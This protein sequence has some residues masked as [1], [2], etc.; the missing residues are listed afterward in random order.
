MMATHSLIRA[1]MRLLAATTVAAAALLACPGAIAAPLTVIYKGHVRSV[2]VDAD[3]EVWSADGCVDT[4]T[5]LFGDH[6]M[7]WYAHFS[8]NY[9]IGDGDGVN[10]GEGVYGGAPATFVGAGPI[11]R[12][13]AT[14]P[15]SLLRDESPAGTIN[16]DEK[17]TATAKAERYVWNE[18]N[19]VP[20]VQT[21][22]A[23]AIGLVSPATATGTLNIPDAYI[24]RQTLGSVT[25]NHF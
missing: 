14:I 8:V 19:V 10:V 7:L 17:W 20:G 23:H 1:A 13:T 22:E 24:I 5:S 2:V 18:H 15:L 6:A 11:Q 4:T 9:C 16:I 3:R 12:V 21:I 25:V